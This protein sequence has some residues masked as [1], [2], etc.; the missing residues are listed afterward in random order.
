MIAFSNL[1][2]SNSS[3][4]SCSSSN[5]QCKPAGNLV[6]G[7]EPLHGRMETMGS[8]LVG[9]R[10]TKRTVGEAVPTKSTVGS[11]SVAAD[12]SRAESVAERE[13]GA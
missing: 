8:I 11:S 6:R 2:G 3:R 7:N 12:S 10:T 1:V 5:C 4:K 13:C 9:G